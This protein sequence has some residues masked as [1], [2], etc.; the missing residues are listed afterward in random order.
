M[1]PW[2]NELAAV[3]ARVLADRWLSET[4]NGAAARPDPDRRKAD[5][6]SDAINAEPARGDA[7]DDTSPR[8]GSA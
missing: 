5:A 8:A 1:K 6:S 4:D 2:W 7:G 3:I